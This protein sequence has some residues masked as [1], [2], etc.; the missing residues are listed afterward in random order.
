MPKATNTDLARLA[1]S[2][3]RRI[4]TLAAGYP[5]TIKLTLG[6][7]EFATPA[8]VVEAVSQSLAAGKTHYPPNN[9]YPALRE[10]LSAYMAAQESLHY[11]AEQIIVTAGATEALAAT[12]QALINPGDEVIVLTPAFG[13]YETLVV[14]AHGRVVPLNIAQNN[15][16]VS[17]D[18]L[19]A[20]LTPATK[21]LVINSPNN[22]TGT[23]LNQAS[24]EAL[25]NVLEDTGIFALCDDVYT[26]LAY[27]EAPRFA[28]YA[29]EIGLKDQIIEINSFS[30]PWAMTG[31]RLGWLAA[32]SALKAQIEKMHQYLI[33]SVPAFLQDAAIVALDT[34][35][36]EMRT[37]YER[38][39]SFVVAE[40]ERVGL[41]CVEPEGAFYAFPSI[42]GLGL[43]SEE[44]CTRAIKEAGVA[45]VP[46]SCF[47]AE[48][49]VRLSYCVSDTDL[50]EGLERLGAFVETLR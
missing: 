22:P 21:A 27:T 24:L 8:A 11:S 17:E 36:D 32:E 34:P 10:A 3:I 31:W 13:L 25:A 48:G 5:G 6:E 28:T 1:T 46:G 15:F 14:A 40:L 45:V 20:A 43:T 19:R 18:E 35:I 37:T 38:R 23:I 33:S 12:I 16:Q 50:Q 29:A 49:F 7:P 41:S 42:E 9:G 39:R 44:F 2:G 4:N 30:K 47:G 26:R